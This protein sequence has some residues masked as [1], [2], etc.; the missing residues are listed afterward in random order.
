MKIINCFP[1]YNEID[2]LEYKLFV[3]NDYVDYFILVES[4]HTFVGNEKELVF[5]KIKNNDIFSKY[6]D[7]IIHIIIDDFPYKKPN[8]NYQNREQWKNEIYQRNALSKGF[9]ILQLNDED[10]ITIQDLD[11][12]VN[13]ELLIKV[14]NNQLDIKEIYNLK[15][16]VF[17]FN[18]KTFIDN[19]FK[20][21]IFSYKNFKESNLSI[22][23]IRQNVDYYNSL[24]NGGWH[25]TWFGDNQ[26]CKNKIQQFSHVE[27]N[28]G[29]T[30]DIQH[31]KN[32]VLKGNTREPYNT[33]LPPYYEPFFT[34]FN[35]DTL[36]N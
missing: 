19:C 36:Q 30:E 3:L 16:N 22:H 18:F 12:I 11:E 21:K 15:T 25:L 7:K 9:D 5:E 6:K 29:N 1:F 2:L 23:E 13:P 17:F 32:C 26:F 14:K 27:H 31:I 24:E 10:V 8:I 4:T 34:K 35:K 28:H 33:E 20:S